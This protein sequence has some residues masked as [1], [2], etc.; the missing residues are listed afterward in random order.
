MDGRALGLG[1]AIGVASGV[2][3]V[4][5]AGN[6]D[7]PAGPIAGTMKTLEDIEPRIAIRNDPNG[8]QPIVIDQAGSYYLA[9]NINALAF[10]H[11]IEITVSGVTLDLNG[12]EI[13]GNSE[14][15]TV[16]GV[17][18][19]DTGT[20]KSIVV[21]NGSIHGFADDGVDSQYADGC[22]FEDLRVYDNFDSGIVAGAGCIVRGCVAIDNG[23]L[24]ISANPGSIIEQCSA[25][26]NLG[27]SEIA[28]CDGLIRG[29]SVSG[30]IALSCA[31]TGVDNHE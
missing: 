25:T 26:G 30:S 21:R 9:E 5:L 31:S 29:C 23:Y 16:D 4:A 2:G 1:I 3:I 12:F 8:V 19:P 13:R 14:I 20:E 22:V 6:V 15:G 17:H 28:A 24:G 11:G 7:P 18:L 10:Q 27:P